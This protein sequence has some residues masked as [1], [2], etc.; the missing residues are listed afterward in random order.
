[1]NR[2]LRAATMGVL[3]LTPVALTACSAGQVNQTA[4]QARDKVGPMAQ[5]GDL[6]LRQVTI[7]NPC[8]AGDEQAIAYESGDSPELVLSIANGSRED[9]TL[10]GVSGDAFD[11]VYV[12]ELPDETSPEAPA[13]PT[14]PGTETPGTEPDTQTP[15]TTDTPGTAETPTGAEDQGAGAAA[16]AS[17]S[18]D[19]PVPAGS[20]TTIGLRQYD[21]EQPCEPEIPSGTPRIFL[22]DLDVD[23]PLTASQ[24]VTVTLTFEN[25]GEVTVQALVAGPAG[26]VERGE[27]FDFHH[28]EEGAEGSEEQDTEA[29]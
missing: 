7:A 6:Q 15:G 29:E 17:T 20:V 1:M 13:T 5:V 18:V 16:T 27:A 19:V 3:L 25:A 22:A 8:E 26:A 9:D 24:T 10:T 23:D 2:A 28:G 11:G 14:E 4:S 21:G 12:G